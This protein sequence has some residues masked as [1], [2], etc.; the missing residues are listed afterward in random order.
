VL[1]ATLSLM[2]E[3]EPLSIARIAE[4]AGVHETSI[5]RRWGTR[6]ALVIDA[7]G[8]RLSA[9]IPV[10]DTGTLRGDLL[11][12]LQRNIDFHSSPLGRQ[13]MRAAAIDPNGVDIDVRRDYWP[14][15]FERVGVIFERAIARGEIHSGADTTL[16]AELLIAPFHFRALISHEPFDDNLV[17]RLADFI[18]RGLQATKSCDTSHE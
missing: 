10:P 14:K 6:D 3:Q 9:E 13:L 5:Y 18:L 16:A 8:S 2:I 12:V 1:E 4:R 11:F 15:R 17:E 7:V